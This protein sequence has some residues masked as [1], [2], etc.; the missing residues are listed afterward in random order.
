MDLQEYEVVRVRQLLRPPE[1]YD[2]WRLNVRP[3]RVGDVG[4]I[5][6]IYRSPGLPVNYVVEAC[7]ADGTT[8]W[9]GDFG[10]EEIE[11]AEYYGASSAQS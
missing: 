6:G 7:E 4:T 9:L 3:P 2:G 10:Q 8:L 1:A 11:R 5:V